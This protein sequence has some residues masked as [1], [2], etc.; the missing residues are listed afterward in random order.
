[1]AYVVHIVFLL[2][3]TQNF[4]VQQNNHKSYVA[5]QKYFYL[6]KLNSV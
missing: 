5:I 6:S 3:L 1:M 2:V 4:S